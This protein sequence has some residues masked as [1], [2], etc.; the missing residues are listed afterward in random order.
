MKGFTL[1]EIIIISM[2]ISIFASIIIPKEIKIEKVDPCN[3]QSQST[4][5]W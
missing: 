2:I 1:L 4:N 5:D 3:E